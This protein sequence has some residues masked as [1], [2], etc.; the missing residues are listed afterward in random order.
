[1]GRGP[2][3][4]AH[5]RTFGGNGKR[6]YAWLL[7]WRLRRPLSDGWHRLVR[8]RLVTWWRPWHLRPEALTPRLTGRPGWAAAAVTRGFAEPGRTA[9][10]LSTQTLWVKSKRD[11][12]RSCCQAGRLKIVV[13]Q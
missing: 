7:D 5:W 2:A 6:R 8:E 10:P 13:A 3:T 4:G 12:T 9:Q 1:M 11:R